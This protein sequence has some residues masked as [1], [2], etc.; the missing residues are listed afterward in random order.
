LVIGLKEEQEI[1]LNPIKL[2]IIAST[3]TH[4]ATPGAVQEGNWPGSVSGE[5]TPSERLQPGLLTSG[6]DG[7]P[8]GLAGVW[9]KQ[10][11]RDEIFEAMLRREVFGTS[12][13]RIVPRFFAGWDLP[14]KLCEDPDRDATAYASAVPMGGDLPPATGNLTFLA[15]AAKDPQ[16]QSL[17]SLQLVKGW[18]DNDGNLNTSVN[19]I[20]QSDS[21]AST[22]CTVATDPSFDPTQSA[23]YY[24]RV[25]E[26]PTPRWH[27]VDCARIPKEERPAVCTSGA[28]PE[29]VQE[30]AWTSPIWYQ[31]R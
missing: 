29:T 25:V 22:L 20:K 23:Y 18:V 4:M 17:Q 19:T 27:T 21:G 13:P 16:G 6:I 11:T 5:S 7:N 28:Y 8:G 2:G 1:G 10:N 15:Y 12:G 9:A 14:D 31:G 24:L 30:M 26:P 3:D